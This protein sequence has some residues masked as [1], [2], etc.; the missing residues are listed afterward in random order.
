MTSHANFLPRCIRGKIEEVTLPVPQVDIIVSEWMGY[1]L[2]FEAM[3]DSVVYARDRYLAPDGLMVP[4]HATLRIAPYT[5]S[6]FI[7]SHISFWNSVYGFKMSSMLTGIYDEANVH[8][9]GPATLAGDSTVFLHLPLHTITTEEL[10]F[11][12]EFQVTLSEDIDRLD[13]WSI[14]FDIFFMPSRDSTVPD[15]A[16]PSEMQKKGYVAFTTGPHGPE[17]HW[18]QGILLIDHGRKIG[19]PLKK[20]QTITGKVGYQKKGEKSRLLDISVDWDAKEGGSGSQKWVL[21]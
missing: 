18:Q 12:K 11:I 19:A 14:W 2:L 1:C 21:Q 20:G 3:F 6:D 8:S 15:N 10:T 13:G 17:T 4:S 16:I 5:D 9:T 7:A